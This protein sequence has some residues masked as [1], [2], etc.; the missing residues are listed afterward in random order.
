MRILHTSDWHLGKSLEGHSRME[1]QETFLKDFINI[2]QKNHVDLIIIAGDIYDNSNPPAKAEKMFYHTLKNLS[3]NGERI[4]LIIA[5]NHDNPDRLVAAEPLARDHGIIMIGTPKSIVARGNY[6]NNKVVNSGEGFIEIEIKGERAVIITVPYPSEKRLNEVLYNGMEEEKNQIK[7]YNDRIKKLFHNLSKNYRKD[8]INILVSHL[9]T[10]GSD[11][12]GSERN[13]QLGGSFIVDSDCFPES[14]QYIALGHI[15]KTQIVPGTSGKARYSGSPIQY[16]KK[17]INFKK[18]CFIVD[19][20][21][22]EDCNVQEVEFKVYKPIEVWKCSSIEDAIETC[23]K[24]KNKNCWVYLEVVTDRFIRED[25]IKVMKTT[26]KDILEIVP[27]MKNSSSENIDIHDF[28]HKSFEEIFREFYFKERKVE[29]QS[30][31]IDLLLSI[32]KEEKED[33]TY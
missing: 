26:K 30:E 18:K 11:Q 10:L 20:K 29:P 15:H 17:E 6:G 23:Y 9:F 3:S 19:I 25:E 21:A 8:T 13:V 27:K 31:V 24:N 14:A 4:T 5:G 12:A 2:V 7:S 16:N 33:E 32:I 28:S 22:G 1:E